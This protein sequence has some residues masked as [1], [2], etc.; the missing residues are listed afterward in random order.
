MAHWKDVQ[1]QAERDGVRGNDTYVEAG[2]HI[3]ELAD[4]TQAAK[5]EMSELNRQIGDTDNL[6]R[7]EKELS[8]LPDLLRDAGKVAKQALEDGLVTFLTDGV[9]EAESLEDALLDLAQTFLKTMQEF[10]AKQM[11]TTLMNALFGPYDTEGNGERNDLFKRAT[12]SQDLDIKDENAKEH[13]IVYF[14]GADNEIV[15]GD[16]HYTDE[17]AKATVKALK[18]EGI[19]ARLDENGKG[20]SVPVSSDEASK[21]YTDYVKNTTVERGNQTLEDIKSE[22][23]QNDNQEVV[24]AVQDSGNKIT[25]TLMETNAKLDVIHGDLAQGNVEGQENN[26]EEQENNEKEQANQADENLEQKQQTQAVQSMEVPIEDIGVSTER[27][28]DNTESS[29]SSSGGVGTESGAEGGSVAPTGNYLKLS[30]EGF[31]KALEPINGF[32]NNSVFG[33]IF[34]GLEGMLGSAG[35]QLGGMVFGVKTLFDGDKKEKLL[36]MIFLELQLIYTTLQSATSVVGHATGGFIRG[37]GTSTSDS[38]PAMLSNGEYVI[39][40]DSVRKYGTNFMNAVNDGTFTQIPL[41]VPKFADG[42]F[43]GDTVSEETARGMSSFAGQIAN[44]V[45]TTTNMSVALVGNQDEAM[46]HFMKS[47]RAQRIMLDFSRKT[48]GFSNTLSRSF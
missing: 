37:A 36:S 23:S 42:G 14:S 38:I 21:W 18:D 15:G 17:N 10:F 27:T 45:S 6:I 26:T 20:Y 24:N 16:I 8:K 34:N 35:A 22:V 28:A 47:P 31:S 7:L 12:V 1:A 2:K 25:S 4:D 40:A 11:V 30:N 29:S 19:I 5:L 13:R 41:G 33:D 43:V 39:S 3:K 9:N 46:E 32:L 48:A 44:N